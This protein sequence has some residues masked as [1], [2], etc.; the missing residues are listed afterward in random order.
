MKI[1][2]VGAGAVGKIY[3]R[4]LAMG[5]AEI[6]FFV[7]EKYAESLKKGFSV[8]VLNDSKHRETPLLMSGY[9]VL[10]QNEEVRKQKW[11]YVILCM[12]ST[13]LQGPWLDELIPMIGNAAL[14][15]LQPGLHDREYILERFPANRLLDGTISIVS[16]ETPLPGEKRLPGMAYWLPPGASAGLSGPNAL[17]KPL[18]DVFKRGNFSV[19]AVN[20]ARKENVAAGPV[21]NLFI[22]ALEHCGWSFAKLRHNPILDAACAAMPEAARVNAKKAGVPPPG[23]LWLFHPLLFRFIMT[24]SR[25]LVPFD[26]ETYLKVHF[27]KVHDQVHQGLHDYIDYGNESAIETRQLQNFSAKLSTG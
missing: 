2:L 15:S 25:W 26:F 13:G 24:L 12:S 16:Y 21:L 7:K 20:D 17:V 27:T 4:H 22:L 18:L 9:Q 8:Y 1:L 14:V 10:S 19:H 3:G 5:G 11:D 6:A 23:N